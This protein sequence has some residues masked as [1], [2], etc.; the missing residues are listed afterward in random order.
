MLQVCKF[1]KKRD[2]CATNGT[3]GLDLKGAI[4]NHVVRDTSAS[5]FY[6]QQKELGEVGTRIR[7]MFDCVEMQGTIRRYRQKATEKPHNDE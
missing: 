7:D 6:N 5:V 1:D 3:L 4:R 2:I